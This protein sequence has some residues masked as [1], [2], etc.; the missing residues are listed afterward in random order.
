MR[1]QFDFSNL[2]GDLLGGITA[3][4]VET[5]ACDALGLA[6]PTYTAPRRRKAAPEQES[7]NADRPM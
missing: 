2:R 1:N 3:G 4:A 5:I 7:P 6:P